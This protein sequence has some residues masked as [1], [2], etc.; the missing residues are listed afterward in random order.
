MA[1]FALVCLLAMTDSQQPTPAQF[2]QWGRETLEMIRRDFYLPERKL[3]GE[4]IVPGQP[5]RQVAFTWGVGVML[6]AL[7]AAAKADPK[8]RPWLREYADAVQS[9]WNPNPPTPGFD[10]L[11]WSHGVDRYYD[12]NAWMVMALVETSEALRDPK[13]L[14]RA[15]AALAYSLSGWDDKLG[16]GI[17]WRESDKASKNT[18]SNGP[19]AAACL[20]VYAHDKDSKYLRWAERIYDWTREHLQ[21]PTDQL[22]WDA[23]TLD[24]HIGKTKWTYNTALMIRAGFELGKVTGQRHYLAEVDAMADS[25]T[26]RWV[27]PATGAIKDDLKFAH[28]LLESWL[29]TGMVAPARA[30]LAFLHG[31]GQDASGHY[32]VRWDS[33]AQGPWPKPMLI[34]QASAARAYFVMSTFKEK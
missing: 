34:D 5:P 24:G 1:I 13:Y 15:E 18:C 16:G 4:E 30:A 25:S 20:A 3:Y 26:R 19:T 27:D 2:A 32:P 23:E 14:R 22:F 31:Q 33:V 11:P 10:V 8:Y 21:D 9:Y 29:R 7:S 12:D 28:L 6:S 17:Y